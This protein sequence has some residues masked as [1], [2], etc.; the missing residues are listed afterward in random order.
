VPAELG[1]LPGHP[2]GIGLLAAAVATAGLLAAERPSL[3]VLVGSAGAF[4]GHGLDP[5]QV[6]LGRRLGLGAPAV[7]LGLGYQP[8]APPVL[9]AWEVAAAPAA[10]WVTADVL[11]NLAITTD[12]RLAARFAEGW[13]VEHMETY[14]VAWACHVA[15]VPFLP[16]LGIANRVGPDAHAEWRAFRGQAEEAARRVAR[17]VLA[18][19]TLATGANPAPG[20][21][22]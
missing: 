2:V 21:Q 20:R 6:V 12:P 17:V 4:P 22:A 5:G 9:P 18:S 16:V 10:Q 3:V 14:G 19:V 15:G 8:A 11:T 13:A 7:T 1:E